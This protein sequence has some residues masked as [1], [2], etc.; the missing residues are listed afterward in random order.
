MSAS[1]TDEVIAYIE[2]Q[3]AHH[4]KRNYEEEFLELLKRLPSAEALG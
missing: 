3:A 2:N 1:Q 4:A